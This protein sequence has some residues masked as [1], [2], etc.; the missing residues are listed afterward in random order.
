M[1]Q[2]RFSDLPKIL[3]MVFPDGV[4]WDAENWCLSLDLFL[5]KSTFYGKI[6]Y[7]LRKNNP[8]FTDFLLFFFVFQR[9]IAIFALFANMVMYG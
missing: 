4:K 5:Y 7:N 9:N 3:K 8:H 6:I 1:E 2:E